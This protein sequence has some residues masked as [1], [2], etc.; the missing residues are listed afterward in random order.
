LLNSWAKLTYSQRNWRKCRQA[1]K[2]KAALFFWMEE[3]A[4]RVHKD[5]PPLEMGCVM[6][7]AKRARV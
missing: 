4:K 7:A 3:T 1:W 5:A 6:R 2:G